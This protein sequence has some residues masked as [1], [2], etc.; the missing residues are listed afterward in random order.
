MQEPVKDPYVS[1]IVL[2]TADLEA[3]RAFYAG[4]GLSLAREQHGHGPVHYSALLGPT[5]LQLYPAG[6]G[7]V[8]F[9]QLALRI[10][11]AAAA[12]AA[13]DPDGRLVLVEPA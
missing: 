9:T 2:Y 6:D 4:L 13:E 12:A 10:P 8:T 11:G 1:L 7:P 3:A 5:M